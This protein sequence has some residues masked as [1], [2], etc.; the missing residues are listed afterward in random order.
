MLK[1]LFS[2]IPAPARVAVG[3]VAAVLAL[4]LAV[5]VLGRLGVS[6]DLF[7]WDRAD[8][9]RDKAGAVVGEHG[10]KASDAAAKAASDLAD[11]T[12]DREEL[13]RINRDDI[14]GQA[15]AG[16]DAGATGDAFLRSLCRRSPDNPRCARLQR[17]NPPKP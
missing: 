7:G 11:R 15:D 4:I 1:T 17:A 9:A 10:K 14:K 13:G 12:A 16:A 3:V 2:F 5:A 6:W 8:A